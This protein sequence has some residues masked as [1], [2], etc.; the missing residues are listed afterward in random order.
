MSPLLFSGEDTM[1]VQIKGNAR[2][3]KVPDALGKVLI[4]R[5]VAYE[6]RQVVPE[7]A[8]EA[9]E[10]STR[11]GQPKRQYRRRDMTAED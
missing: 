10:I 7:P 2:V 3:R 4:A 9:V 1:Q 11:T 5:G 6:V 8:G